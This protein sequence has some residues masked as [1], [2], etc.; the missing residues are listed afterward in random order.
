MRACT[1]EQ[2]VMTKGHSCSHSTII[3]TTPPNDEYWQQRT[4][5]SQQLEMNKNQMRRGGDAK[6]KQTFFFLSGKRQQIINNLNAHMQC[7]WQLVC[8]LLSLI[9]EIPK[10]H[11]P[12]GTTVEF[13]WRESDF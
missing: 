5:N 13:D 9:F 11:I 12:Y 3:I 8:E 10:S 6:K 7:Q 2:I 4:Q 1:S